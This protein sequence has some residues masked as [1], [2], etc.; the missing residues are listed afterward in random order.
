MDVDERADERAVRKLLE[1]GKLNNLRPM[2]LKWIGRAT[3]YV[4]EKRFALRIVNIHQPD[5]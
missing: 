3:A 5:D 1:I 4:N 2:L